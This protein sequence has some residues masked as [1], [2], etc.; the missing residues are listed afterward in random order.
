MVR[1][2]PKVAHDCAASGRAGPARAQL[3]ASLRREGVVPFHSIP[4]RESGWS[5][6]PAAGPTPGCDGSAID[7]GVIVLVLPATHCPDQLALYWR[8]TSSAPPPE[9]TWRSST[10]TATAE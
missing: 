7:A 1:L 5:I 4:F 3:A 8:P 9:Q 6:Q 2:I 10:A